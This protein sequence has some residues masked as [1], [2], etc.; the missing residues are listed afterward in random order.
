MSFPSLC[1][2]WNCCGTPSMSGWCSSPQSWTEI[3]RTH[4]PPPPA[5]RSPLCFSNSGRSTNPPLHQNYPPCWTIKSSWKLTC[6]PTGRMLSP[7]QPIVSVLWSRPSTCAA[8]VRCLKGLCSAFISPAG[9]HQYTEQLSITWR[10]FSISC[11][12]TDLQQYHSNIRVFA[13]SH[14]CYQFCT[15]AKC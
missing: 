5:A 1:S 12:L 6:M 2:L 13:G 8:P 11:E 9:A 7:W 15:S 3:K 14:E 10:A 4:P